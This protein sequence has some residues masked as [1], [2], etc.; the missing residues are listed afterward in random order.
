MILSVNEAAA[1]YRVAANQHNT[2]A[3]ELVEVQ[4]QM[5][6]IRDEYKDAMAP[7]Q[8]QYED[9]LAELESAKQTFSTAQDILHSAILEVPIPG[10][11]H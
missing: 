2:I 1:T 8:K 7:L 10:E 5:Q 3:A 6:V 9:K 4:T 11:I